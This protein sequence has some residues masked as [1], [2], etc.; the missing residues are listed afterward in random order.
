MKLSEENLADIERYKLT[1]S[2]AIIFG[3]IKEKTFL[4]HDDVAALI[5][6]KN[7]KVYINTSIDRRTAA[8]ITSIRRKTWAEIRSV[9]SKGY[10]LTNL[11]NS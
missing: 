2:E 11:N 9:Y 5:A 8:M 10:Q 3:A 1:P 4:T 6:T 7:N